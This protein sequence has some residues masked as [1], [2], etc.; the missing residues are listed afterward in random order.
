MRPEQVKGL[1]WGFPLGCNRAQ[2]SLTSGAGTIWDGA[3]YRH[4]T[5]QVTLALASR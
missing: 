5:R 2:K 3:C 4:K 1:K